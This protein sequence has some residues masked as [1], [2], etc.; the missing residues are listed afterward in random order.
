MVSSLA[1]SRERY[2]NSIHQKKTKQNENFTP[3]EEVDYDSETQEDIPL[4]VGVY[5]E[6]EVFG[7]GKVTLLSGRGE[8][9]KAVV[10][11]QSVGSKN[12]MVK[13]ARLRVLGA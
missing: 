6:H 7:R 9:A 13:F 10:N 1:N 11:F 4:K 3:D 12:L 2:L 5:V 8:S